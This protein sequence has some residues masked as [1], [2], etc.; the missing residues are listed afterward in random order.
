MLWLGIVAKNL[1]QMKIGF[2]LG[3]VQWFPAIL[4]YLLYILGILIFATVPALQDLSLSRALVSGSLFGFF[5]YATYDLTNLATIKGWPL[6]ITL[7]DISW[8]VVLTGSVATLSYL[9]GKALF[10]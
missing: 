3:P 10:Y 6:S 1:Y 2:L 8:G 5:A 4:F 7:I 9:I